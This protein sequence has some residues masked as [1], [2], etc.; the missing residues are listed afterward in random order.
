VVSSTTVYVGSTQTF[1]ASVT[2]T[3][4]TATVSCGAGHVLGGGG[5]INNPG[6]ALAALVASSPTPTSN[7]STAT[8]WSV[9]GTVVA[10]AVALP[11]T[12]TAYVVCG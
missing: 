7:G 6:S 3:S 1:V 12:I 2:A 8:G 4:Q 9:T 11:P 5:V 10:G